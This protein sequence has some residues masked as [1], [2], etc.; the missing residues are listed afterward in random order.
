M[1]INCTID[2]LNDTMIIS[3][4]DNKSPNTVFA[5][6]NI[7]QY[8]E[9]LTCSLKKMLRIHTTGV[10]GLKKQIHL[11]Y[12]LNYYYYEDCRTK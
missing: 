7:L 8:K 12:N 11:I 1:S 5:L 2:I 9:L 4:V 10:N 6:I 3:V